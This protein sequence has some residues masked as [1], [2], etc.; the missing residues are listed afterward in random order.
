MNSELRERPTL[1]YFQD[2]LCGWCYGF[3][4][5]IMLIAE[6]WSEHLEVVVYSGGMITGD[7]TRALSEMADSI[8]EARQRVEET[9]GVTFGDSFLHGLLTRQDIVLD[10]EPPSRA[11]ETMRA[12]RPELTLEF[13]HRLQRA[14]YAD[15]LDLNNEDTYR[16]LASEV[17]IESDEFV[18]LMNSSEIHDAVA[19]EFEYVGSLGIGGFPTLLL[20][21]EDNV[22]MLSNGYAPYDHIDTMLRSVLH[23]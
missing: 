5:T 15:G 17:G 12:L 21:I 22:H 1:H 20:E 9:T 11:L 16:K 2:T 6:E 13:S 19:D 10:S 23:G 4:P 14:L 7:N 8:S 3:G 18:E